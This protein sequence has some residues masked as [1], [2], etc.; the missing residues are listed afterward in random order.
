MPRRL[1][2]LRAAARGLQDAE[3]SLE[4]RCVAPER[5]ERLPDTVRIQTLTALRD[6]L[7]P[8]ERGQTRG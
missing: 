6:V 3:L 1:D 2:R 7:D 5:L 8:R 4:L